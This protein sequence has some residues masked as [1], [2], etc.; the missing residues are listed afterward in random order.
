MTGVAAQ[1]N[2]SELDWDEVWETSTND[3]PKLKIFNS[4]NDSAGGDQPDQPDVPQEPEEVKDCAQNIVYW[5][6]TKTDST[7]ADNGEKGTA[8]D[9]IIIDS[10]EEL[11]YLALYTGPSVSTEKHYKIADNIDVI[12]LQPEATVTALG[13]VAKIMNLTSAIAVNTYFTD[14][15]TA[16]YTPAN[17]ITTNIG[18]QFN[19]SF[20]G[21]GVKIYGMYA[22]ATA[23][24]NSAE[25]A[26]LFPVIDGGG[27]VVN[28]E[29]ETD[30]VG[31]TYKDIAIRN[32]YISSTRRI[33][34]LVATSY[35]TNYG[36]KV[37]GT[38]NIDSVEVSNCYMRS[39]STTERETGLLLGTAATD[40]VNINNCLVYGNDASWNKSGTVRS[41]PF[42]AASAKIAYG[43]NEVLENTLT[44][45]IILG[46]VPTPQNDEAQF[47]GADNIESV[48]T[49]AD[50]STFATKYSYTDSD[51]IK[52]SG[53]TDAEK[54]AEIGDGLS[55]TGKWI[56]VE[57]GMP[58]LYVFH[59]AIEVVSS[60]NTTHSIK[61]GCGI[62]SGT[63]SHIYD[64]DYKCV[65]CNYQHVHNMVDNG[66]QSNA[67][68]V[69]GGIMN[70]KCD[71]CDYTSTREI[72]S[73]GHQFGA[74]VPATA[75]DCKTEATIAY[76]T[77]SV[78]GLN[79]VEN[80]DIH[81]D[82]PLEHIGTGY[83]GRH[84][85]VEQGELTSECNGIGSS[86]YFKCSVCDKYL[87][88]GVMTDTEPSEIDGHTASGNYYLDENTHANICVTCG[89]HYH[90]E[91]HT[92]TD[93]DNICDTCG[94]PCGEY[95]F[96]GASVTLTDSIAVNYLI[97]K[98]VIDILGYENLYIKF[99]FSGKDYTVSKYTDKGEYYAFTFDKIAPDRMTDI[100][101]ATLYATKD[102]ETYT[103]KTSEYSIRHYCHNLLEK[104]SDDENTNLRTLLVD[105]L[106]YGTTAQIYTNYNT[107]N[108]ANSELSDLQ[109]SWATSG[110]VTTESD[111][112][113]KY[114]VVDNPT[115]K[116]K[117][118]GL[119]LDEAAT[120][121]LT[122]QTDS[123]KNLVV[124]AICGETII[125]IPSGQFVKL[126]NTDNK[127]YIYVRGINV[128]QM[129][130]TVQLTVYD[131]EAKASNTIC[132]SVESYAN[133]KIDGGDNDLSNL[134]IA[135]IKYGDS[136]KAYR[137]VQ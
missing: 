38:I 31:V 30:L 51:M 72:T 5:D 125:E 76:K 92:D 33:G 17:W 27:T 69:V 54:G 94:W 82:D 131:G 13:G 80:A 28:T 93:S 119:Y 95:V 9:P 24:T 10:A 127:Y 8:N 86:P 63:V 106:N 84:Y 99:N 58:T 36:G 7:L 49:D 67:D 116:W 29:V 121:R 64:D 88:D 113:L 73:D 117:G 100:I 135:M 75:G 40:L 22:V 104:Y 78:C 126:S 137:D 108:L 46:I 77:C 34:A 53:A 65:Q 2:M 109:K 87:I 14:M 74:V 6:N 66:V 4:S 136:A 115:V 90:T 42:I 68:C 97:K 133:A 81:S 59:D 96:E 130:E 39:T 11:N 12:I 83:V 19:G 32:S 85:W 1:N 123:V 3:F 15:Q 20:D 45:S 56:T 43:N 57:S 105:L 60:D 129:R 112:N 47:N 50:F 122:I 132:Y 16:G 134:L 79:F 103:S 101:Y 26:A 114:E 128:T 102:G 98:D 70:T 124:K 107:D 118:A 71:S 23:G 48:Y 52:L 55:H 120:L 111:Q 110:N 61:C 91:E 35:G 41:I 44:N 89:E 37:D 21:N 18:N 62:T 25:A